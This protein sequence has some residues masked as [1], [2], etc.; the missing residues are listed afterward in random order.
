MRTY[1]GVRLPDGRTRVLA[2]GRSLNGRF[3][4]ETQLAGGFD[5]GPKAKRTDRLALGM[6]TKRLALAILADYFG[7]LDDGQ[8]GLY[9]GDRRA[10]RRAFADEQALAEYERFAETLQ[11]IE[12]DR[13]VMF[14][15]QISDWLAGDAV[16]VCDVAPV[17]EGIA[18]RD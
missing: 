4:L 15:S 9:G 13:W 2:D 3:D 6:R 7:A 14:D 10:D 1:N 18:V 12:T 8:L 11:L 16:E 5:W 17:E